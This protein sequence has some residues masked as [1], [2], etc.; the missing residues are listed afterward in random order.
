MMPEVPVEECSMARTLD[1]I[2]DRWA[3]LILR[4][5]FYGVRRF[6]EMRQ[7]LDVARNILSDR[8]AVL[9]QQELLERVPYKAE[10][11]RTRYEYQL[12]RKGM[13]L[14][15]IFVALMEW[16]DRYLPQEKGRPLA[17]NHRSCGQEV[18]LQM[19][20]SDGHVVEGLRDL[21]GLA[22][23]DRAGDVRADLSSSLD[24]GGDKQTRECKE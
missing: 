7:D 14:L 12:T 1:L 8:L 15:P 3:L 5:A 10:G 19:V 2:G 11:Q 20:C 22:W 17:L 24:D 13:D 18:R 21:K 23:P 16:G 6:D 4:E 9:V